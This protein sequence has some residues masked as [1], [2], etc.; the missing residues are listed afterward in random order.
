MASDALPR[1]HSGNV[2]SPSLIPESKWWKTDKWPIEC[3]SFFLQDIT[4]YDLQPSCLWFIN[5]PVV[6]KGNYIPLLNHRCHLCSELWPASIN[7]SILHAEAGSPAIPSCPMSW[8]RW[9]GSSS[10][11]V[12]KIHTHLILFGGAH[13]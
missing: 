9:G 1:S 3:P 13:L 2:A 11:A 10:T 7:S 5:S 12:G 8:V 6:C 4:T